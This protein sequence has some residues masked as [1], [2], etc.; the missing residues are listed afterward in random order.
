MEAPTK[1]Q[2][3]PILA[4][5]EE[6]QRRLVE[7]GTR[8]RLI[9]VNRESARSS[10]LNITGEVSD[11]IYGILRR[12][13]KRMQF[14]ALGK[15]RRDDA[16]GPVFVED[17]ASSGIVTRP[18]DK[19]LDTR[20]GP[21][22]LQKRLL[23]LATDAR[24]AEEEQG[25]NIL[26]LALGFVTWFED[27]KSSVPRE[28][29]LVLLPV[30]L[31][32]NERGSMFNLRVRDDDLLTNLP[33]RE[34]FK[35]DFGMNLP[36]IEEAEDWTPERYFDAVEN[37][38]AH[39]PRWRTERN[40]IQLGFFSFAKLL[41]IHDLKPANWPEGDLVRK[42]LIRRLLRDGFERDAPIFA[43][44]TR[45]DDV[46]EPADIVQVVDADASQ[47]IVVEEVRKG[48]NLV[49]Q[50]PPGTGK[51]QTITNIVAAAVHDGKSVLFVAEKMAALQVVHRRLV[52][53]GLRDICIELHSRS[54]NK[55]RVLEEIA[56]TLKAAGAVP[57]VPTAPTE[58]GEVRSQLNAI[59]RL[60]HGIVPGQDY[61]PFDAL[62]EIVGFVGRGSP[63]PQI[64]RDEL[65]SLT[66]AEVQR[67]GTVVRQLVAALG[68][69][70]ARRSHP[71]AGVTALFLQPPDI[72]RLGQEL[73][74]AMAALSACAD[75]IRTLATAGGLLPPVALG[76]AERLLVL[77]RHIVVAPDGMEALSARL[78]ARVAEKRLREALVAGAKWR[79]ARNAADALFVDSAWTTP[80][81]ELRGAIAAG[82]DSF[83]A[84]IFGG[85]RSASAR[86]AGSLR[87]SLP[88]SPSERLAL[89]DRLID[90]QSA[91]NEL[92]DE[93]GYLANALG[94]IWRGEKTEFD[95][96]LAALDWTAAAVRT[97][98]CP[99]PEALISALRLRDRTNDILDAL[100]SSIETAKSTAAAVSSRL[101][102]EDAG[103]PGNAEIA[104]T[105]RR[106]AELRE[107][108]GRYPEWVAFVSA[109]KAM[110]DMGLEE[111]L[112][113]IE[114]GRVSMPRALD[115]FQYSLAEAR[116]NAAR[117][118][119]PEL[120]RLGALDRH[121]LV[122]AFKSLEWERFRDVRTSIRSKHLDQ[123]PTGAAGEMGYVRGEIAKKKAHKPIRKLVLEAGSIL[124]RIK[125]V[126]L[127]SPISVAQ[128]LPPG[129][130]T[131]DLLVIDEASQVRPEEALGAIA[132]AK[133]IVVVGDQKQLPPTSFFDRLTDDAPEDEDEDADQVA[134]PALVKATEIESIL[135]LCE[136][137]G[138]GSR[139]LKWH[140]RS[141]DPSLIKV[142]NA[143]FYESELVLPPSPLQIDDAYGFSFRRVPGIYSSKSR[144]G[145]RPNT[146]RIEAEAIVAMVAQ[147][148]RERRDQSLGVVAFSKAQSD[149]LG[150]V[151]EA[152][153]RKDKI[154]DAFLRDNKN[155]NFFIKNI[156]NV[157]GDERDVIFVSVGY[158]PHEPNGRLPAMSFGPVNAEGGG[159]RLNVLFSRARL[160]CIAVA[161]FDPDDIDLTKTSRDGPRI[162]KRFLQFAKSGT[163]DEKLP[164]GMGAAN[165]FEEDVGK[166][167]ASLGYPA[168]PQVGSVGFRIDIGVRDPEFT[169][170]YILAIEC[171]G[172]TWHSALWARERDRLR[173][174]VLESLGWSFH[175]IWS[176]DW[177]HRREQEIQRL[178]RALAEARSR[179]GASSFVVGANEWEGTQIDEA[180]SDSVELE[181]DA[182]SL[183]A[184]EMEAP[185]YARAD[186]VPGF[187]GEPHDAPVH[188][189]ADMVFKIVGIE[190]PIH[191]DEIARRVANGVG[192][193]RAG[194]R[195]FNASSNAL[196]YAKRKGWLL[197]LEGFWMTDAQRM[198]PPVR[199]RREETMPT[200]K[201]AYLCPL[202][203]GAAAD[204]ISRESGKVDPEEMIRAVARMLGYQRVG[205]DLQSL[206]GETLR[207]R[208][209]S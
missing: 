84:R 26:F 114:E 12:S 37:A 159:R 82:V 73:D 155:E 175:R 188:V 146:N 201:A 160:R 173:Q 64:R 59:D 147:H 183:A 141:K 62:S 38:I 8:N 197:E 39:L 43:P 151:L 7:T 122:E 209:A 66:R 149:M 170:R 206:I 110:A 81:S 98:F 143:E 95:A 158:G 167:V 49:V 131:F 196:D 172:A 56:R 187:R 140:Y 192:K 130:V 42:D 76:E 169:G 1:P 207:D 144:G 6:V 177:F 4:M 54:A 11:E 115:E 106:Y 152:A 164:S 90:V 148:A 138:L 29:P 16:D 198:A 72:Q 51:S 162:L 48:R 20:L 47:T 46:L 31:V 139:M 190:G 21:D 166:V 157:Q 44:A 120:D 17:E 67:A 112:E 97:G 205:K 89:L 23:R 75:S 99:S 193:D 200:T 19:F 88:K 194:A 3:D 161:S 208:P 123:L 124:K 96:L 107:G 78:H 74:A 184:P 40:A 117:R 94:D 133:Q 136:A 58:L 9:H 18:D 199:S 86:L 195:I 135:S 202:E 32:R 150:E 185:A 105:R 180:N 83:F 2:T 68:K 92:R 10:A 103:D 5:L 71:F 13:G 156:E 137:R 203:I 33:L 24:T 36:E 178:A 22:A 35:I 30:E 163:L 25:I 80:A 109:A 168:D 126:F 111:L 52:D 142:S 70:G 53:S 79:Q 85:Y 181:V 128:F 186:V 101:V 28:A 176:T 153:R 118:A 87:G 55:K 116:W 191:V 45:L 204:K 121:A 182:S 50:G 91:R 174:D 132:R 77:A 100:A 65:A 125:P 154:L 15:D 108:L 57:G 63:P 127:M 104:A 60:L 14:R 113:A 179:A 61:S 93:E 27:E 129:A 134:A 69:I 102:F 119:L 145:G 34:R 41:M 171:D 165:P 189:L